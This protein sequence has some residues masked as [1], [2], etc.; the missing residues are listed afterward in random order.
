M[1]YE[2]NSTEI[3]LKVEFKECLQGMYQQLKF[4]RLA[5]WN[6]QTN[7]NKWDIQP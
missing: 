7:L 1:S 3:Q 6:E 5:G 2:N 4:D